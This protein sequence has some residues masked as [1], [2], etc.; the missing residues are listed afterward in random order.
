[1]KLHT[2]VIGGFCAVAIITLTVPMIGYW[3]ARNLAVALYE[4]GAVRLPSIQGLDTV[5]EAMRTIQSV[6]RTLLL[7]GIDDDTAAA[8]LWIERQA[9]ADADRGWA[10]YEPLPQTA[11]ETVAWNAFRPAWQEWKASHDALTA[12]VARGR[13]SGDRAALTT[14]Q[15]GSLVET[16]T[17]FDRAAARLE[18]VLRINDRVAEDAKRRSIA[19]R[20]DFVRTDRLMLVSAAAGVF[21]A[22]V[23]GVVV[24]RRLSRPI[25]QMA[26]ALSRI[27]RGDRT[28]RVPVHSRDEIGEM[29]AAMNGMVEALCTS[30]VER[31]RVEEEP[32]QSQ[33][34]EAIG[35]LAGGIAH[36][37][38]NI[39]TVILGKASMLVQ[40][41]RIAPALREA[42]FDIHQSGERAANLTRQLLA[43]SRR[44]AILKRDVD[45]NLVVANL[46]RLLQRVIGEDVSVEFVYGLS[47]AYVHADAGMIDQ[48]LLNLAVNARD[49]MPHGGRIA[50]ETSV[51]D[52]NEA[53]AARH[54]RARAGSF[55]C[56]AVRDTGTGIAPEH[57]PQIFEPFFTTK[58]VGKGT[59][60]GLATTYGI[61]LQ[62]DGWIEVESQLWQGST[63]RVLLPRLN[64]VV[65]AP[66]AIVEPIPVAIPAAAGSQ[67]ILVVEDEE[68][69]R[70][71]VVELLSSLGYR[72]LEAASGPGAL[73]VWGVQGAAVDLLVTDMVMPDGMTGLELARALRLERPRLKVIFTSGY[74]ADTA[75]LALLNIEGADYLAKPFSLPDLAGVVRRS[76]ETGTTHPTA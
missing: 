29:A 52:V 64:L 5:A 27:A 74:L 76:L 50:I 61:V 67:T 24:G 63:F 57:L 7:P 26:D 60:L 72:V 53:D 36:D 31:E 14:A 62:H 45:L 68:D 55:A 3:E 8:Q 66:P 32:R 40:D 6:E 19:S 54:P 17:L 42:A 9:W 16:R 37:F 28:T 25:V 23:L 70:Q 12:L 41:A 15:R 30:E 71:L 33:K 58:D 2:K 59:G 43:F 34:M 20:E 35:R 73:D 75:N 38:N 65:D 48:V 21:G 10:L 49:A 44:Q 47:P 46:A 11:D 51:L 1:M 56:I 13:A 22:I 39:L 69:V 4:V 18:S